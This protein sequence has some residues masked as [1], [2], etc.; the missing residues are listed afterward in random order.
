[1]PEPKARPRAQKEVVEAAKKKLAAKQEAPAAP[2]TEQPAEQE[3][4]ARLEQLQAAQNAGRDKRRA[5]YEASHPGSPLPKEIHAR[6]RALYPDNGNVPDAVIDQELEERSRAAEAIG[7]D[8]DKYEQFLARRALPAPAGEKTRPGQRSQFTSAADAFEAEY[9]EQKAI[10]HVWDADVRGRQY[11]PGE[12]AERLKDAHDARAAALATGKEVTENGPVEGSGGPSAREKVDAA[13]A[14][15]RGGRRDDAVFMD[16]MTSAMDQPNASPA[17][18]A[19][20]KAVAGQPSKAEEGI[21]AIKA[22]ARLARK[23]LGG[24]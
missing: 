10:E 4:Y 2:A 14:R 1:M 21:E 17:L 13:L 19:G 9:R 3:R 18:A 22:A 12:K 6:Y 16:G 8:P 20:A 5:D 7:K 24:R 23:K 15:L 11:V